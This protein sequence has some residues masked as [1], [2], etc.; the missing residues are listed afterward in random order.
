MIKLSSY[1][2]HTEFCDGKSNME[3]TIL[4]AINR[5]CP[6]IGFSVHSPLPYANSWAIADDEVPTYLEALKKLRK[7]YKKQIKVYIGIE[8]DALSAVDAPLY[9]YVIGSVHHVKVGDKVF[10]VDESPDVTRRIIDEYFSADP[11]LYCENYFSEVEAIYEK[12]RCDIIGHFDLVTKFIEVDPIF[13][14]EHPRYVAARDRAFDA[15]IKTPAV[16]EVNTGAISRGYRAAPYPSM[17][18]LDR[19]AEAGKPIVVNADSHSADTVDFLIDEWAQKLAARGHK[20]ITSMN[21]LLSITRANEL[22]KI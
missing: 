13:D 6:E 17:S 14:V 8:Q 11:Y 18:I 19:I 21:E 16:F 15:L 3:D 5:G 9:D 2:T 20:I 1:H 12:T 7:S 4:A 10:S 22:N